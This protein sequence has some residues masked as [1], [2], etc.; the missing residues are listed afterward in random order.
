MLLHQHCRRK[1]LTWSAF[2][3]HVVIPLLVD[4]HLS[5]YFLYM[6]H[7]VYPS[8]VTTAPSLLKTSTTTVLHS[9]DVLSLS[10]IMLNSLDKKNPLPPLVDISIQVCHV[11]QPPFRSSSSS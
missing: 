10:K 6:S 11:D 8:V 9:S 2:S 1:A 4:H 3:Q 5:S 7:Q